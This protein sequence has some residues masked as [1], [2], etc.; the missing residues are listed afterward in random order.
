MSETMVEE[1]AEIQASD[2]VT[3]TFRNGRNAEV[4]RPVYPEVAKFIASRE[5]ARVQ[6]EVDMR[7][8]DRA[9]TLWLWEKE[10]AYYA[11]PSHV[12]GT[13]DNWNDA[14]SYERDPS[15]GQSRQSIDREYNHF[16]RG[17]GRN[18]ST[19]ERPNSWAV[20]RQEASAAGHKTPVWII[21]N[22]MDNE[23]EAFIIMQYLPATIEELW[24]IA[25]EDHEMCGVFDRYMERAEAAGILRDG[26][27]PAALREMRALQSYIRRTFGGNYIRE[28]MQRVNPIVKTELEAAKADAVKQWDTEL[29][30]HLKTAKVTDATV[31]TLLRALAPEHP[32]LQTHL[33][34]S[35]AAKAAHARRQ[36]QMTETGAVDIPQITTQSAMT[37]E[38]VR[39][40]IQADPDHID[41]F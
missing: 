19:E 38:I 9:K 13:Y 20:L 4:T 25:K 23:H 18:S 21:D 12:S 14:R 26:D 7:A 10:D 31:E 33:N 36:E 35:D 6:Y 5:E 1:K 41:S 22:C 30:E 15:N 37:G 39:S 8:A 17:S 29:L 11:D 16:V 27:V 40:N 2:L 34:R 28:F 24:T 3:I 32:V